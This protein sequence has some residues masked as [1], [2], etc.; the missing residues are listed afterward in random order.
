[1]FTGLMEAI[2]LKSYYELLIHL[3]V[4]KRMKHFGRK[5]SSFQV[6]DLGK[7]TSIQHLQCLE[8]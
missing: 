2:C 5:V 7:Q 6:Q 1:M 8:L 4:I 3:K